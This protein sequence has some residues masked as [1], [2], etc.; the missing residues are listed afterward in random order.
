MSK[1]KRLSQIK[2][3]AVT[4]YYNHQLPIALYVRIARITE[5]DPE[6]Y[7]ALLCYLTECFMRCKGFYERY[8]EQ[9]KQA[10]F[11]IEKVVRDFENGRKE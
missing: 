3:K 10:K 4:L 1:R 7:I 11:E 8:P 6:D 5:D 2:S 9:A